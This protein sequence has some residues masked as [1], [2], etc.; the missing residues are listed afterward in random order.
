MRGSINPVKEARLSL[1]LRSAMVLDDDIEKEEE[2]I[3]E[4]A[5]F[6]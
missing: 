5:L 3:K 6:H 2:L 1:I 4:F